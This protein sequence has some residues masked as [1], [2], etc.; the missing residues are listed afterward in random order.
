MARTR[1]SRWMGAGAFAGAGAFVTAL[2]STA[3]ADVPDASPGP[4][5]A[6][7]AA[8]APAPAT[9]GSRAPVAADRA[10]AIAPRMYSKGNLRVGVSCAERFLLPGGG[11]GLR[12]TI[13]GSARP[14][15]PVGVNALS[16]LALDEDDQPVVLSM[17]TD[18]GFLVAPGRHRVRITADDCAPDD[19]DVEVSG[20]HAT[21]LTG[22]LPIA[23]RWL[24]GPV[25][26]PD[27]MGFLL[28]GFS[29]GYP[30]SLA[31]GTT[32]GAF[33]GSTYSVDT[34]SVGGVWMSWSLERR[35]LLV[36]VDD[37]IGWGSLSGTVTAPPSPAVGPTPTATGPFRF[38]GTI[39]GDALALRVGARLPLQYVSLAAG[40]GIGG[41]VWMMMGDKL[42]AGAA[43]SGAEPPSGIQ[44]AW[45]V[46][47]WASATV[48]PFCDWGVQALGAYQWQPTAAG[49]STT[50]FGVGLE[51]QP[52]A[53]C[54]EAPGITVSPPP[55]EGM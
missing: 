51:W 5:S 25:G 11:G 36:A 13:D 49:A 1:C 48:K 30:S 17:P 7:P 18:V 42:E 16:S 33:G 32:A 8:A 39:L 29:A 23:N 41:S 22:R 4:E 12:V 35:F 21:H 24:D 10:G 19:R 38:G 2:G 14:L 43:T 46:P 37:A 34:K 50:M 26:A 9:A 15:Q 53:S 44:L 54:R 6:A 47:L 40:G 55:V 3:W 52:S 20:S 27:G 28:G 45:D 31:S